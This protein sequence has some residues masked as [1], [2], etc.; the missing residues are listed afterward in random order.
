MIAIYK[1]NLTKI[2]QRNVYTGMHANTRMHARERERKREGTIIQ[3]GVRDDKQRERGGR[4]REK[5]Q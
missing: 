3:R 1:I 2:Y 4:G 5:G